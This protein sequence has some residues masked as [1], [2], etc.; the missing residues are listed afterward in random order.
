VL[1][2]QGTRDDFLET[3]LRPDWL[4]EA[5]REAGARLELRLQEGYDHSYYFVSSFIED[6]LR[7]HARQLAASA[8]GA[9]MA[10]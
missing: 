2:D 9:G 3:Q 4:R 7:R 5:F 8:Q 6:H 1:V 10:R